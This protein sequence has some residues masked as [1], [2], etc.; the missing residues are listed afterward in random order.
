MN[1]LSIGG[2][3]AHIAIDYSSSPNSRRLLIGAGITG[4]G[5]QIWIFD[6]TKVP[7]WFIL[8]N[9]T[10][11]LEFSAAGPHTFATKPDLA[12]AVAGETVI[13]INMQALTWSTSQL[14][15]C[16]GD[17]VASAIVVTAADLSDGSAVPVL[18]GG[19]SRSGP[20][21]P[22]VVSTVIDITAQQPLS[23]SS[24]NCTVEFDFAAPTNQGMSAMTVSSLVG[25][26]KSSG[27][28]VVAGLQVGDYYD[29]D[30]PQHLWVTT[31]A[32]KD[33]RV[34]DAQLPN[35]V[36][37]SMAFAPDNRLCVSSNGDG[38][39]CVRLDAAQVAIPPSSRENRYSGT[40]IRPA[41]QN[42]T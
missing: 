21:G 12:L 39:A 11:T 34:V 9:T 27:Q 5:G 25:D 1:G 10:G 17:L 38:V 19:H 13:V 7:Q 26:P 40:P 31:N 14:H 15:G 2:R 37:A 28:R 36:V 8:L 32:G 3:I 22:V 4:G 18:V 33:W 23:N 30:V 6:P 41:P 24:C 20:D 29:G 42:E 35:A 16:S